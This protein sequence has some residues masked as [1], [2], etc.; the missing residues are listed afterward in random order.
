MDIQELV[1]NMCKEKRK[2]QS[3]HIT[4]IHAGQFNSDSPIGN[5][6]F[7]FFSFLRMLLHLLFKSWSITLYPT[8][9]G[10]GM[11]WS[12]S[13]LIS[14]KRHHVQKPHY[15]WKTWCKNPVI[16]SKILQTSLTFNPVFFSSPFDLVESEN[17]EF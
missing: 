1:T 3:S 6:I 4:I 12:H 7:F 16:T 9:K 15:L 2:R 5:F 10:L 14:C 17:F 11:F 13:I 8:L